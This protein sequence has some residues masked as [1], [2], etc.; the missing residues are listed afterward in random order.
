MDGDSGMKVEVE[1]EDL[2]TIVFATAVIKT[3]EGALQSRKQDPFVRP[4]LEYTKAH[5]ALVLAMNSA[6]R[7]E[8][9]GMT[10]TAWDGDLTDN[11]IRLLQNF[12]DIPVLVIAPEF[13]KKHPVDSLTAKGCLRIG[14]CVEG[15]V[16]PGESKADIRPLPSFAIAITPRGREKLEKML[17]DLPHLKVDNETKS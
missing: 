10:A 5:D 15:A 4:H 1:I 12:E 7:S 3:V 13:R 11:E 2:E 9:S 6:R 14:Q 17:K 8:S 16:W